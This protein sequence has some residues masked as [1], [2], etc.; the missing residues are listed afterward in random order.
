MS[1]P[2]FDESGASLVTNP[3]SIKKLPNRIQTVLRG[4]LNQSTSG[5]SELLDIQQRRDIVCVQLARV[6]YRKE[7]GL[8]WTGMRRD[9]SHGGNKRDGE[10]G[11]G[12]VLR[13]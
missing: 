10:H 3:P 8:E 4:C 11:T 12:S 6:G 9:K 5:A 7:V 13:I 2:K 1:L